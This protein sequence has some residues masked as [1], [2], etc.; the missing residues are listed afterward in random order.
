MNKIVRTI[1]IIAVVCVLFFIGKTHIWEE[2]NHSLSYY[3]IT[4]P[5]VNYNRFYP[6][7]KYRQQ[8]AKPYSPHLVETFHYES[9]QGQPEISTLPNGTYTIQTLH[10]NIPLHPDAF[11]PVQCNGIL[12]HPKFA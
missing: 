3:T 12:L 4:E 8:Y 11:T 6:N 5:D 2:Y 7:K 1:I 10:T 9:I